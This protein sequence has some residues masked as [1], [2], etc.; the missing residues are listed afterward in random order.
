MAQIKTKFLESDAVTGAKIRLDNQQYLRGRNAA[1]SADVNIAKV[2]ASDLIEFSAAPYVGSNKVQTAADK[3]VNNGL[4]SL[5]GGGKIPAAQLPNTVMEYQGN[6][7]AS[8]NTPTL[9]NGTGSAGDVY[10][11]T[12]IGTVNFGAG[13]ITFAV[14]DFVIY[15]GSIWE[16]SLNSNTVASV[17]SQ[18]G[19]V[20]LD[21]D[22]I[23]EATNLY[24]TDTRARTAAVSDVAYDATSW[25][26][27]VNV[28]PSKNSVRDEIEAIYIAIGAATGASQGQEVLT[29]NG[30]DISN[31]YKALAQEALA[32]SVQVTPVGGP[33]QE[34][35]ADYTL[36]VISSVTRV[37]FAGTLASV[38]AS[39]DKLIVNYEY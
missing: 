24:F 31:G 35:T 33:L 29:L 28:A 12:D 22:D 21:T 38:L 34:P 8:T 10:R 7:V 18:T 39:G 9:A 11:A 13:N 14:G 37:T 5:D 19:V 26:A 1:D 23:S 16:K 20:V 6:W 17:N 15:S 25:N 36:S 32:G 30:T 4:A 3:G 2:N 27:V